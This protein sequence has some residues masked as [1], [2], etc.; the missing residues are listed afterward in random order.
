MMRMPSSPLGYV[1]SQAGKPDE[2]IASYREAIRMKP[3]QAKAQS[4]LGTR[5]G[6]G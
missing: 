5:S 3:A 4:Y 6:T 1:L 2:A